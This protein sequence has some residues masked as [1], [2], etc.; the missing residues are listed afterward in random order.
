MKRAGVKGFPGNE[1]LAKWAEHIEALQWAALL[2]DRDWRLMWV[3]RELMGF[4]GAEDANELGVGKHIADAF[5]GDPWLRTVTPDSQLQLMADLG[6]Y[7]LAEVER[8]YRDQSG[9]VPDRFLPL[10]EGA[11]APRPAS[12]VLDVV[13]VRSARRGHGTPPV[14][15]QRVRP[16]PARRDG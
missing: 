3:S 12:G 9:V 4:I 14:Q 13:H 6:P 5:L 7:F 16:A 15:G 11:G 10:L 8:K 2:V 1:H